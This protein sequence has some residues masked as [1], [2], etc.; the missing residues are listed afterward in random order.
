MVQH[1]KPII[2]EGTKILILGSY[3]HPNGE[4][5]KLGHYYADIDH[6][7]FW[8]LIG[9]IYDDEE[10]IRIL[11]SLLEKPKT[12]RSPDEFGILE[13]QLVKHKLGV[14]DVCFDSECLKV[15]KE[16]VEKLKM[17]SLNLVCFNGREAEDY[18]R[19]FKLKFKNTERL[20]NSSMAFPLG[21]KC[22]YI[23]WSTLLQKS[24]VNHDK[25][26]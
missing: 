12:K 9:T 22:K 6:N 15:N 17:D 7:D 19:K 8:S 21:F 4:S 14:A 18:F 11:R 1:L 24:N 26:V 13:A 3:P 5:L 20:P 23:C 2:P 25:V 10:I 16:I